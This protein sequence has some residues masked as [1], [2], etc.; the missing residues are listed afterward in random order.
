MN[1]QQEKGMGRKIKI[2]S[3]IKLYYD[4]KLGRMAIGEI[5]DKKQL[6]KIK[7]RFIPWA[8]DE[9]AK[10]VEGWLERRKV[11]PHPTYYTGYVKH[12]D[13]L[14]DKMWGVWRRVLCHTL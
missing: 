11:R 13:S 12:D 6:Y 3:K 10:P 1:G 7:V 5:I 9:G 14:M 8:S 2:G 4:G